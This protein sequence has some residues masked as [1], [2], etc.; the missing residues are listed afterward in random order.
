[1]GEPSDKESEICLLRCGLGK[2]FKLSSTLKSDKLHNP[3]NII[4]REAI[5]M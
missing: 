4:V 3:E 1:M 5:S 2:S